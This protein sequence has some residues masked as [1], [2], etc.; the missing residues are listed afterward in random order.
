MKQWLFSLFSGAPPLALCAPRSAELSGLVHTQLTTDLFTCLYSS[1]PLLLNV[2]GPLEQSFVQCTRAQNLKLGKGCLVDRTIPI[3]ARTRGLGV[4]PQEMG[5]Y[6]R[7][8]R[9]YSTNRSAC[10]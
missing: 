2:G 9:P 7:V 6:Y 10:C 3:H 1:T 8:V 4:P 5:V